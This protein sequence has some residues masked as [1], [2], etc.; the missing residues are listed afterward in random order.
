MQTCH[1]E[2][3]VQLHHTERF[4]YYKT[5]PISWEVHFHPFITDFIFICKRSG[6]RQNISGNDREKPYIFKY[7]SDTVQ[8]KCLCITTI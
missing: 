3:S 6:N 4:L 1:S 2:V 7:I 5:A 8:N